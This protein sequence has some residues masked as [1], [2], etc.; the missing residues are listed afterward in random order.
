MGFKP[1]YESYNDWNLK[2]NVREFIVTGTRLLLLIKGYNSRIPLEKLIFS[3]TIAIIV[4]VKRL[5]NFDNSKCNFDYI[6]M[7]PFW[8]ATASTVVSGIDI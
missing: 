2:N 8:L 4:V 6:S 1:L 3:T 7:S 5:Y